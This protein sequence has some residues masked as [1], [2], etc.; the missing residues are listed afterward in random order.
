ML[1]NNSVYSMSNFDFLARSFARMQAEGRPVDIQAVTGNMDEEH[2]S[3]FCKR[4]AHYCQQAINARKLE[5]E[6]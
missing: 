2:R 3:W 4:Y 6:H 5:V 1:M